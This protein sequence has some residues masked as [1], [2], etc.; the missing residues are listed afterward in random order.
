MIL[1]TTPIS[2]EESTAIQCGEFMLTTGRATCKER[3]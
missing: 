1:L 2:N 3:I